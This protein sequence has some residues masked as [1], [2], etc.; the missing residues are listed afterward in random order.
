[1]RN[2]QGREVARE[3]QGRV[4]VGGNSAKQRKLKRTIAGG[5]SESALRRFGNELD[6]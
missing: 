1:M 5:G 3:D 4:L 6:F 2:R